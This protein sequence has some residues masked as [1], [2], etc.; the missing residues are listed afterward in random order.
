MEVNDQ[1]HTEANL[2]QERTPIPIEAEAGWTSDMVL[3]V[4]SDWVANSSPSRP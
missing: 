2:A 4:L 3:M 1:S